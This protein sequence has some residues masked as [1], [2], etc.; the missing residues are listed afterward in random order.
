MEGKLLRVVPLGAAVILLGAVLLSVGC[1][2]SSGRFRFIQAVTALPAPGN[3]DLQVDGKSVQTA[4]G[5]GQTATYRTIGG[6]SHKFVV[7]ASGTTTNPYLSASISVGSYTT[8]FTAGQF[9]NGT[10]PGAPVV[11]TD[12]N[13]VPTTGNARL[14]IIDMSPSAGNVDIYVVSPPGTSIGGLNPQISSLTNGNA[15]NYL[16]LSANSYD[17]VVTVSGQ[18]V[19]LSRDSYTLTS[20]Q[21]RTVVLLDNSNGGLP[22]SQIILNDLN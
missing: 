1:G 15:S 14:R 4:I 6:G 22:S 5:F 17:V 3:V 8:I 20:G 9:S 10:I 18:Q 11:F 16:Q 13:T 12:D 7:F 21:V 19:T 2:S